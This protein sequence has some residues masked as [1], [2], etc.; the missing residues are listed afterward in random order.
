MHLNGYKI[1]KK[2]LVD[3]KFNVTHYTTEASCALYVWP[4]LSRSHPHTLL[5][6]SPLRHLDVLSI[7]IN[8]THMRGWRGVRGHEIDV[9]AHRVRGSLTRRGIIISPFLKPISLPF[10]PYWR[11]GKFPSGPHRT[12]GLHS[13]RFCIGFIDRSR[14]QAISN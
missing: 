5:Y 12:L 6:K 14:K 11:L 3:H 10:S 2:G 8:D 4:I 13:L 1:A 7:W 9:R